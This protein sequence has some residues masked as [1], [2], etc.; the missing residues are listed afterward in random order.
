MKAISDLRDQ[1]SGN[2]AGWEHTELINLL[3]KKTKW[4]TTAELF[5]QVKSNTAQLSKPKIQF[6]KTLKSSCT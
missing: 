5:K 4:L 1:M 6:E 2:G 3:L